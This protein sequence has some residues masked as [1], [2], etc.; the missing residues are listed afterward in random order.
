MM[1]T[2]LFEFTTE[3]AINDQRVE[4]EDGSVNEDAY[5]AYRCLPIKKEDLLKISTANDKKFVLD[6]LGSI[7]SPTHLRLHEKK[8][9]VGENLKIP[10]SRD[11]YTQFQALKVKLTKNRLPSKLKNAISHKLNQVRPTVVDKTELRRYCKT[12]QQEERENKNGPA[13]P[14]SIKSVIIQ[15]LCQIPAGYVIKYWRL[16]MRDYVN[17]SHMAIVYALY[18]DSLCKTVWNTKR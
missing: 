16:H 1:H 6:L 15:F 2:H 18:L 12:K 10:S 11:H 9:T 4:E 17:V 7:Y 14:A 8:A 13:I 5:N 3:T